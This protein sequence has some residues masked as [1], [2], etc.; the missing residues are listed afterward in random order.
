MKLHNIFKTSS[1]WCQNANALLKDGTPLNI[2]CIPYYSNDP[3]T[4]KMFYDFNKKLK[5]IKQWS[6]YGA[7]SYFY[8]TDNKYELM[9]RLRQA[10]FLH[11]GKEMNVAEF[12]DAQETKFEDVQAVLKILSNL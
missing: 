10:I 6:L 12:N 4:N 8:N 5:N 1:S 2:N 9:K 7:V 3:K 11:T